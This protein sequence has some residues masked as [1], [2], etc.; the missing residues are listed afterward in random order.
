M[1]VPIFDG[2][3]RKSKLLQAQA[4]FEQAEIRR[5]DFENAMEM[6]VRNARIAYINARD[7]S[8]S[9]SDA[10]D[11]AQSIY[12]VTQIKY[13][14]GVGSSV[15]LTQAESELY[16]AQTNYINALYELIVA[17]TDLDIALGKM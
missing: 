17:K 1:N 10:M 12:D 9:R 15:E 6:E 7:A 5:I 2:L 13:R 3:E 14:E 8:V 16:S 4:G 11:L